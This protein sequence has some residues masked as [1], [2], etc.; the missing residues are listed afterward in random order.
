MY[1]VG[2][3]QQYLGPS[4]LAPGD[5]DLSLLLLTLGLFGAG[6]AS[7]MLATDDLCGLIEAEVETASGGAREGLEDGSSSSS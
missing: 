4:S 7:L 5:L 3:V 2:V 6:A 1:I